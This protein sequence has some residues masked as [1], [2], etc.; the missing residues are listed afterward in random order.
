MP[1]LQLPFFPQGSTE[2]NMNLGFLCENK[3]VTYIYGHLPIFTHAQDDIKSFRLITSQF[4]VIGSAKQS[5]ISRAFG[6]PSI[7]V[8]RGVKLYREKGSGAFYEKRVSRG[9]VVLTKPVLEQ[10]QKLFDEEFELA[11]VSEEIGV[12]RDTLRKAIKAGR[13]HIPEKKKT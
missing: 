8:K 9:A 6:V 11:E 5:E 7:S 12:K 13:L 10:A 3:Q 1:Q 4:C 2:I